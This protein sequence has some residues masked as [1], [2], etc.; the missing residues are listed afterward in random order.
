LGG[1]QSQPVRGA[2]EKNSQLLPGFEPPIIQP[3]TQRHT[4]ELSTTPHVRSIQTKTK[5]PPQGLMETVN[6]KFDRNPLRCLGDEISRL[7]YRQNCPIKIY[8]MES[9]I[10]K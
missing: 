9:V 5:F 1:P 7:V 8:F 10:M 3:I 2:E 6:M 4:T